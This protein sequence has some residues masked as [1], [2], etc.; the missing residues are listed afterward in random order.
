MIEF[1]GNPNAQNN[2]SEDGENEEP[3]IPV[4]MQF[5]AFNPFVGIGSVPLI[6]SLSDCL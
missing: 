1:L 6:D 3:E 5:T 4:S 2:L